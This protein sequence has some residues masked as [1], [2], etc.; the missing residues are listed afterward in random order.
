[1]NFFRFN[2]E[3]ITIMM[4]RVSSQNT[5]FRFLKK[6]GQQEVQLPRSYEDEGHIQGQRSK[7]QFT[8]TLTFAAKV[9]NT[10]NLA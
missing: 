8:E 5:A 2:E 4:S 6:E 10:L 9:K 1:M 3:Q 7:H